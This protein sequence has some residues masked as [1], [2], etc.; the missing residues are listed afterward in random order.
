MWGD[1]YHRLFRTS[2]HDFYTALAE[3]LETTPEQAESIW[4]S[5]GEPNEFMAENDTQSV[6]RLVSSS[7]KPIGGSGFAKI[8]TFFGRTFKIQYSGSDSV[9]A[10]RIFVALTAGNSLDVLS[11]VLPEISG[12]CEPLL[13]MPGQLV[14]AARPEKIS[15][16]SNFL[17]TLEAREGTLLT[18]PICVQTG[19]LP[20][21]T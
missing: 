5:L 16:L 19:D 14:V 15:Q 10:R 18:I 12:L 4:F 11:L 13:A 1:L 17:L 8:T 20:H 7:F 9:P 21:N 2:R 3:L 6:M